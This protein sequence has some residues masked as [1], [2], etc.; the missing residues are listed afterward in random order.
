MSS[1]LRGPIAIAGVILGAGYLAASYG[2]ANPIGTEIPAE[3]RELRKEGAQAEAVK[4]GEEPPEKAVDD[5]DIKVK[6][7]DKGM[8]LKPN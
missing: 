8:R 7:G 1:P 6:G 4:A 3:R 5:V 2:R